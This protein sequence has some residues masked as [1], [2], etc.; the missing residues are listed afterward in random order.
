MRIPILLL[1]AIAAIAQDAPKPAA[2]SPDSLAAAYYKADGAIAVARSNHEALLNNIKTALAESIA[3]QV[4]ATL[5]GNI[6]IAELKAGYC[7]KGKELDMQALQQGDL[8]CVD[9]PKTSKP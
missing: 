6:A 1:T 7:P 2:K 8:A 4:Q 3:K 5:A 9:S